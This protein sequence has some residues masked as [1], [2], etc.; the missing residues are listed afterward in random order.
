MNSLLPSLALHAQPHHQHLREGGE[1]VQPVCL[2]C[3]AGGA[4]P[5]AHIVHQDIS[6]LGEVEG[7]KSERKVRNAV[8]R[9]ISILP[10]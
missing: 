5:G 10:T 4:D 6:L 3:S 2:L 1:L 8:E 7:D 9:K